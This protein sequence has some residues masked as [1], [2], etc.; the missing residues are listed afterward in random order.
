MLLLTAVATTENKALF[1]SHYVHSVFFFPFIVYIHDKYVFLYISVQVI[2]LWLILLFFLT[3][4]WTRDNC[5]VFERWVQGSAWPVYVPVWCTDVLSQIDVLECGQ[6]AVFRDIFNSSDLWRTSSVLTL[7][8]TKKLFLSS[9]FLPEMSVFSVA[10]GVSGTCGCWSVLIRE[11]ET[12]KNK[13]TFKYC[14]L[15][16]FCS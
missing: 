12:K 15:L 7:Y 11:D 6:S 8:A 9:H 1:I 2:T 4:M 14:S 3:A 13:I 5:M 10:L 16:W